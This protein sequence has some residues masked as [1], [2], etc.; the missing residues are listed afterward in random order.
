MIAARPR[1]FLDSFVVSMA[2]PLLLGDAVGALR[3]ASAASVDRAEGEEEGERVA[4]ALRDVVLPG[5]VDR[6]TKVEG[7]RFFFLV[8]VSRR[9]GILKALLA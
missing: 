6:L 1:W 9:E 5:A 2:S 8:I 7:S 3:A 4:G